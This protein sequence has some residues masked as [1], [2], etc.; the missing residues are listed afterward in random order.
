MVKALVCRGPHAVGVLVAILLGLVLAGAGSARA[1]SLVVDV[2]SGEVISADAPNHLWYPASLTK[3]MTVY[4]ALSEIEAGRLSF[5]DKITV[6]TR[7][8]GQSPVKFGLKAGQVITV[9]QAIN[10]AIV[11]SA[12]DAAV[13]LAEKVAGSEDAFAL[14]MTSTARALGM[15]RTVFRN[16]TGLPNDG[17]VTTARDLAVLASALLRDYPDHYPLFNQRSVT[18]GKRSRGTVNS[19]LGSYAGADGFKTG[20]TCG[21]GYNLVASATRDR[22]R[23]IGVVLGSPNRG[24]R[25]MEMTGLLNR[26]F[27]AA[28]SKRTKLTELS[29]VISVTDTGPAP[30]ILSGGSCNAAQM[31]GEE[32]GTITSAARLSGWGVVFGAYAQRGKA[33]DVLKSAKQT[34]GPLGKGGRPAIVQ[35]AYEGTARYSAMLV[36]LDQQ[37]AGQACKA[38][39][40]KKAYCLALSPEVLGNPDSVWR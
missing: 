28:A 1:A 20:F 15:A 35:K 18:I 22:R 17:Q 16:A 12:N 27:V 36:G 26:A 8:A 2:E 32:G 19:I 9:Q 38:L 33:E 6:S 14:R 3:M 21:S 24:Q 30:V 23:L 25:V 37:A 34:L 31:A 29:D 5:D 4:L 7:A 39:W 10:A 13:A 40:D 11:A